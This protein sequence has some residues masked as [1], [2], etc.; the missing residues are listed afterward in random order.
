LAIFGFG[1]LTFNTS[2]GWNHHTIDPTCWLSNGGCEPVS[3]LRRFSGKRRV[4]C[5]ANL[6]SGGNLVNGRRLDTL[7]SARWDTLAAWNRRIAARGA[8][9]LSMNDDHHQHGEQ[10]GRGPAHEK[11]LLGVTCVRSRFKT[12]WLAFLR[13]L[14]SEIQHLC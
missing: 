13:S 3:G 10:N 14:F 5:C 11:L 7:T 1:N 9:C 12:L 2:A 8:R 4:Q 6:S